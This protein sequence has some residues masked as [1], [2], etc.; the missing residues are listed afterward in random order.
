MLPI[1]T[2][3]E[4]NN[5]PSPEL[6]SSLVSRAASRMGL[7]AKRVARPIVVVEVLPL[8]WLHIQVNVT[9]V[10]QQYIFDNLHLSERRT[11]AY[12]EGEIC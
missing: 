8:L 12:R 7:A 3:D 2:V 11:D 5:L 9:C 4:L 1:S 10:S 6:H